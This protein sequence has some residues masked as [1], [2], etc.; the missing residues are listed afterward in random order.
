LGNELA[1]E[2]KSLIKTYSALRAVNDISFNIVRDTVFAFLG[3]NGAG[4]TTTVE[5]L[6]CLKP[7]T[8]GVA[9]VLGYNVRSR[10]DQKEIR[11]K[12]GVLPQEFN[13][14]DRLTVTEN[15]EFFGDMFSRRLNA[16]DLINLVGL[17]DK[18]NELFKNLSGGLKQK[19]G[20]AIALVN[21]PE[22]LFLDEP[23]SGLDPTARREV[24][25][26]I[27]GLKKRGKTVFLTTH[28]MEEAQI[29]AD[30]VGIIE[31]GKIVA[32][33]TPDEL[34]S[35]Y[36]GV[37][38]LIINGGSSVATDL[39]KPHFSKVQ[40]DKNG[41]VSLHLNTKEELTKAILL[42][43]K[44]EVIREFEVKRPTL[45]TVYLKLTG[46]KVTDEGVAQ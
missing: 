41:D 26:V 6:E 42:L 31:N 35:K 14:V 33:G 16:E 32:E 15:I 22:M 19:L 37:K 25:R 17:K 39:L 21:D 13:A 34:I 43:S 45:E 28:Y 9:K 5:I 29:L 24:W 11:R 8:S 7:P 30:K 2:V 46:K 18:E 44:S 12:I 1:V 10:S 23:T 27:E 3:P 40:M 20:L 4:K 36:G 38:M